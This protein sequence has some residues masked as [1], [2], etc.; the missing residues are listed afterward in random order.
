M[1]QL[2]RGY[3]VSGQP[4]CGND[5]GNRIF[6]CLDLD[7]EACVL[8]RLLTVAD[9]TRYGSRCSQWSSVDMHKVVCRGESKVW[10]C[11]S[12]GEGGDLSNK[13]SRSDMSRMSRL[14]II[15]QQDCF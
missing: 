5:S 11:L 12:A 15:I 2:V 1:R 3:V 4:G 10:D 13:V 7:M 14:H 9:Q 6:R 8:V